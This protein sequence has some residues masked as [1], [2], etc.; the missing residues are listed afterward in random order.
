M[1]SNTRI[2]D[3]CLMLHKP[4]LVLE[5]TSDLPIHRNKRLLLHVLAPNAGSSLVAHQPKQPFSAVDQPGL[6]AINE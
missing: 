5:Q 3:G 6:D 1:L 2:Y 4:I